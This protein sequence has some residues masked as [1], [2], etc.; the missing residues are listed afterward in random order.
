MNN[1]NDLKNAY[2][3][4]HP[5]WIEIKKYNNDEQECKC[6]KCGARYRLS[7]FDDSI[8]SIDI[9]DS[10]SLSEKNY[11]YNTMREDFFILE[12]SNELTINEIKR[13]LENMYAKE[14]SRKR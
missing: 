3:C 11:I 5:L 10:F 9:A 2:T 8:N 1:C 7:I 4:N 6:I 13:I 12:S 14:Y